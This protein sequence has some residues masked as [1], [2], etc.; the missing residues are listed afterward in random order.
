MNCEQARQRWHD[1]VDERREDDQLIRHL[2]SC[3]ACR[4]YA[5]QMQLIVG[6][7]DSLRRETETVVSRTAADD[8]DHRHGSNW[9]SLSRKVAALA[10][11]I[12]LAVSGLSHYATDRAI[13]GVGVEAVS[14]R[15]PAPDS[16]ASVQGISLRGKYVDRLLV[17]PAT[18]VDDNVQM[19]WLY[20]IVAGGSDS[21]GS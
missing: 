18:V 7:L 5:D 12:V 2:N 10:A 14:D 21:S 6:V 15:T 9:W 11:A 19:Y 4:A 13:D 8:T 1:R 16:T 20:P 3:D 17:V